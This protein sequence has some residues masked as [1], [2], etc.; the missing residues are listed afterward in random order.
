[1]NRVKI[2]SLAA[3]GLLCAYIVIT[4]FSGKD[5][6]RISF[7]D[8]TILFNRVYLGIALL[9]LLMIVLASSLNNNFSTRTPRGWL[10]S[11]GIILIIS[12]LITYY[13]N[14]HDRFPFQKYLF[15]T[16]AARNIKSAFYEKIDYDPQLII[17]GTSRAFTLSPEYISEKTGYKTYN[18]SV[19]G[20]RLV[21][22]FWQL[23]YI[24][25]QHS[26]PPQALLIEIGDARLPSGLT[27]ES[28]KQLTFS[29]Q[30]LSML[31]YFSLDQQK[32]VILAY[33]EDIL[34]AQSFSDSIYLISHPLL[35]PALQTWTFQKD[36]DAIRMPVTH[37][38]YL[39]ALQANINDLEAARDG[40]G[41]LCTGFE[42]EGK[43]LLKQLITTAEQY[44]I[45]VVL[46]QSPVNG[47]V[48]QKVLIKNEQFD[49]CQKLLTDFMDGL[50]S[51]HKNV[52]YI[53]LVD[54]KA[55]TGMDED[56]FYDMRHLKPNASQA[57]IDRLIPSIQSA[58][59]WSQ[60]QKK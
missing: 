43:E 4:A 32:E 47:T 38:I 34:S 10:A 7:V 39:S 15:T 24:I 46:Y 40:A 1:M 26:E 60:A 49:R 44:H 53:N 55:I 21:D 41:Y 50:K 13:A 6:V 27:P 54:D 8:F 33:G 16:V 57:V 51:E 5:L 23:N 11:F 14:P 30:P 31:P 9:T 17:M 45:G 52:W 48:L 36:G 18:F 37:E 56:G 3:A 22:F 35:T 19:E 25:H 59:E 28:T 42:D 2:I 29:F 12:V 20:A 58:V